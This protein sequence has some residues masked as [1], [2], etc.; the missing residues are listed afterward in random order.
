MADLHTELTLP[1]DLA[2]I[3]LVRD[4][5]RGLAKLAGLVD[6]DVDALELAADEACSNVVTHAFEHGEQ[7]RFRVVGEISP[8]T[9]VLAV[10]EQG[11]PFEPSLAPT[12]TP[13]NLADPSAV[14]TRGLGLFLIR[15]V[16]DEAQWINHGKE[17]KELRLVKYRPQRDVRADPPSAETERYRDD[18]PRA[19]EQEYTI[20]RL[21][22]A[23]AIHVA[24]CVYRAYGYS[25]PNEDLYYPERI[26]HLNETGELISAVAEDASGE[27]VGHYALERH[28][29]GPTAESGQAIVAPAHRGRKLMERMRAFLEAEGR[30]LGLIGIYGQPVTTHV[31]SQRVNESFGSR[32]CGVSLGLL[33]SS[34][35]FKA[36]QDQPLAQRESLMLY[37]KYLVPPPHARVYAP[38]RHR[39]MLERLYAHLDV[40]V[41]FLPVQ[42]LDDDD[43]VL[44]FGSGDVTTTL[45][46]DWG[47]ATI[48][49]RQIGPDTAA[50][51]RRLRRELAEADGAE[52]ILL[53]LPLAQPGTPGLCR[54]AE[55]AGFFFSRLG[56]S[57]AGDGDV[58]GLQYQS[59]RLD[60]SRLQ[61]ASPFGRELLDYVAAERARVE[62]LG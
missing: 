35:S 45:A 62:Q 36:I 47:I 21:V 12:F 23:D 40:P 46:T 13:E 41:E 8:T 34:V 51:V 55:Q 33:S 2:T 5:A 61:I 42:E 29:L 32:V 27:V 10:C 18:E 52:F 22:P 3:P 31:Y 56:P 17:G 19:P 28:N 50:E 24:R 38:P 53:E 26:L 57:F 25:Y 4:Y 30:G 16:V 37:F 48:R 15:H 49:V 54:A 44:G 59:T 43:D 7:G 58:L 11:L 60:T 39:A 6:E 14:S 1:N 9:L 20:R